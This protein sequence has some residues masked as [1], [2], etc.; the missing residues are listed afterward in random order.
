MTF[1]CYVKKPVLNLEDLRNEGLDY[2]INSY[3]A[4]FFIKDENGLATVISNYTKV[5]HDR[6]KAREQIV[7]R[8]WNWFF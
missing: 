7:H 4:S 1:P 6:K 2:A 5:G 3:L 8:K